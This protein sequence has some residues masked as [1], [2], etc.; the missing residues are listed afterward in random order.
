MR[1]LFEDENLLAVCKPSGTLVHRG[2][3]REGPVLVDQIREHTGLNVVHPLHRLD[4]GTSGVLI[5]ALNRMTARSLGAEFEA[6]RV[7]KEY[8]VLVRGQPPAAGTI[9]HPVPRS[10]GG[11]RVAA[12]TQFETWQTQRIEPR[13]LSLVIARPETGRFHQI[14]RHLKHIDHPVIGD[15]NYGRTQLNRTI[16]DRFGLARLALHARSISING[17]TFQAPLPLDLADPFAAM[18]FRPDLDSVPW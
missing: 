9:D 13:S 11:S 1:V 7:K 10:E 8:L 16:R 6:R 4:R 15:A 17:R 5:F 3:G 14:R 18:G 2:I 12:E